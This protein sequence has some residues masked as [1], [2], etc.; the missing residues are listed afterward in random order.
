MIEKKILDLNKTVYALSE[1]YPEFVEV[2][3]D[4]GFPEI[5]TPG[6]LSTAGRFMTVPRG[7]KMKGLDLEKIRRAFAEK[8]FE[9]KE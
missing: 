8:G 5:A 2:M 3:K 1:Q 6:L 7:A 4:N 9:V